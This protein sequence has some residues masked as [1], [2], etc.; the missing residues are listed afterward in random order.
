MNYPDIDD[1]F[2]AIG[3]HSNST[4]LKTV[5]AS[6]GIGVKNLQKYPFNLK[7]L[8]I[9]SAPGTGLQLEFKD[10]GLIEDIPYHDIDEGPWVLVKIR[11]W[12]Q[13]D[14][15]SKPYTGPMPYGLNFSMA[16]NVVRETMEVGGLGQAVIIGS[17][18][19]VD[20]WVDR[21]VRVAVGYLDGGLIRSL[22]FAM[23][24]DRG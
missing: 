2:S 9:W 7:G 3:Q 18:G 4:A 24:V 5:F 20:S 22:S 12:A 23:P 19:N 17:H 16:R 11:F 13:P 8:R 1:L 21:S 14:K 15:K 6:L 10:V